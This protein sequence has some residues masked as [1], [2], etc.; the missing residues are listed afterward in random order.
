MEHVHEC[1]GLGIKLKIDEDLIIPNK[2]LS[3]N[4][5]AIIPLNSSDDSNI[6]FTSLK[7]ACDF[8]NIDMDK[9]ISKLT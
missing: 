7:T 4:E 8:Y 2:E 9:P 6:Y 1:K 3:I 5:G